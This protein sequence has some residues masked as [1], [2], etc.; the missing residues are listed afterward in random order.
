MK[1]VISLVI[2][3]ALFVTLAGCTADD[4]LGEL[5]VEDGDFITLV[6]AS[7][8]V[9]DIEVDSVILGG[10]TLLIPAYGE[11]YRTAPFDMDLPLADTYYVASNMTLMGEQKGFIGD[12]FGRLTYD[13]VTP[14]RVALVQVTLTVSIGI[15]ADLPT[16]IS[17]RIY[18]NGAPDIPSTVSDYLS[19]LD[20][21]EALPMIS[22]IT[23]VSPGDYLEIY[24][25]SD[26][27]GITLTVETMAIITTTVD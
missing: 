11:L 25:A 18:K 14:N 26:R 19:V 4:R 10:A 23:L 15:P 5:Y 9:D 27:A 22:L 20:N 21:I 3:I 24:V 17:A 6:A 2:L 8:D 16:T 7:L 12:D 13:D 1:K